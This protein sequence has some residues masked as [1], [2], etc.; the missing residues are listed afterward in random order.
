M[1]KSI[2]DIMN[3]LTTGELQQFNRQAG[4]PIVLQSDPITA[5]GVVVSG[6]C[7]YYGAI[8]LGAGD[9]VAIYDNLAASGTVLLGA[10]TGTLNTFYG[11]AGVG[12]Q[13]SNG[14]YVN[15]TSGTWVVLYVP[16]V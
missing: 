1:L 2:V 11:V 14:I 3:E 16:G 4:G 8:C 13:C 12:R 15:W 5:D 9:I 10:Q 6:P 7:I